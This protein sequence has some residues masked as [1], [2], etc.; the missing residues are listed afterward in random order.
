MNEQPVDLL[1][2]HL[3]PPIRRAIAAYLNHIAAEHTQSVTSVTLFGSQA[4]GTAHVESDIDLLILVREDSPTL[5]RAL[6]DLAWDIQFEYGVVIADIIRSP[7]E[8]EQMQRERF[9]FYQNIE[10]EGLLLWKSTLEPTPVY[11]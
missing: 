4:R 6:A 10:R 2:F 7:E 3:Q 1:S 9:P 11:A 5:R 8:W